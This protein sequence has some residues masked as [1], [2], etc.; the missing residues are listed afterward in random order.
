VIKRLTLTNWRAYNELDLQLTDGTTFVVAP[1]GVGKTSIVEAA[2]WALFADHVPVPRQP[3]RA[4]ADKA[5]VAVELELPDLRILR[6]E[7]AMPQRASRHAPTP[8]VRIDDHPVAAESLDALLRDVYGAEPAFLAR[9]AMP[10]SLIETGVPGGRGLREHLCRLFGVEELSAA[11]VEIDSRLRDSE[12]RIKA[13]KQGQRIDRTRLGELQDE[14]VSCNR[15]LETARRTH[16]RARMAANTADDLARAREL[17][18]QWQA[19]Y[20]QRQALL[21]DVASRAAKLLGHQPA[22]EDTAAALTDAATS[23]REQ[24]Q[25]TMRAFGANDAMVAAVKAAQHELDQA[26]ADCPVCRRPLDEHTMEDA[27]LA[28]GEDL[29]NLRH[30][31]VTLTRTERRLRSSLAELDQLYVATVNAPNPGPRPEVDAQQPPKSGLLDAESHPGTEI[32]PEQMREAETAAMSAVEEANAAHGRAQ[33][34]LDQVLQDRDAHETLVGLFTAAAMLQGARTTIDDSIRTFVDQ[35]IN[36]IAAELGPRWATLFSGRGIPSLDGDGIVM[37]SVNGQGLSIESFSGGERV[38]AL[39]LLRLLVA[40]MTTGLTFCWF[41]EP[42]EHLDPTTRRR[43]AQLLSG[44]GSSHPLRQVVLTTY[45]EPL[46]ARL[47]ADNPAT[48][49][50][51]S[52]RL[53]GSST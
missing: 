48:V 43:V 11:L 7:R 8:A 19:R 51:V 27:R 2:A 5:T 3:V 30:A 44:A 46:A 24:L 32:T 42:L 20:D 17:V 4:G 29:A 50:L 12:K 53:A 35:T 23:F 6:V 40:Q 10:P 45:E 18:R 28:H 15:R 9:I 37:R 47:A 49:R 36:P 22:P 33:L 1:N 41:D 39:V 31:G 13:A 14:L 26:D 16:D 52:V 38:G 21:A 25:T 34:S